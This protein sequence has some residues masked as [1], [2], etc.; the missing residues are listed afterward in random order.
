LCD[1]FTEQAAFARPTDPDNFTT[2]AENIL[3]AFKSRPNDRITRHLITNVLIDVLDENS[4]KGVC[5]A[6]LFMAPSDA[7]PAMFGIKANA[8]QLVGEF[9]MDFQL[10]ESGWKISRQSGNIIFST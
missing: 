9:Y 5:Y 4:A 3:A 2:G 1:L 10:T 8:S 7:E 6:T